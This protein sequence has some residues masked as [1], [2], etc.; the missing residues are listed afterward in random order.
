MM[1]VIYTHLGRKNKDS[2]AFEKALEHNEICVSIR[3]KN[4]ISAFDIIS[5]Y[6]KGTI[7]HNLYDFNKEKH[8]LE[9]ATK[10]LK[11]VLPFAD[12]KTYPRY[13]ALVNQSL[14][15]C[16][17]AD[18]QVEDQSMD[19][20]REKLEYAMK[21]IQHCLSIFEKPSYPKDYSVSKALEGDICMEWS[22]MDKKEE[23]IKSALM[24]YKEAISVYEENLFQGNHDELDEKINT[25]LA[26][27]QD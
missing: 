11:Q 10:T 27:L 15:R 24:H 22:R 12:L 4:K 13:F 6:N 25:C 2:K 3:S 14:C 20:K 23:N 19:K 9:E 26:S 1:E 18:A 5:L 8:I 17:L 7:L 16:Y 21:S